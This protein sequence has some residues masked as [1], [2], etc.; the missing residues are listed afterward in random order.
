MSLTFYK[1]AGDRR[2]RLQCFHSGAECGFIVSSERTVSTFLLDF[3][4]RFFFY[5]LPVC[6]PFELLGGEASAGSPNIPTLTNSDAVFIISMAQ[7]RNSV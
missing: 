6:Y 7:D 5:S 2:L 3:L 1:A 4:V